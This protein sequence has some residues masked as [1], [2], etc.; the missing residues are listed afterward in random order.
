[1]L[2][3]SR[4]SL[5]ALFIFAYPAVALAYCDMPFLSRTVSE[6]ADCIEDQKHE[7]ANQALAI[8]SLEL[9]IDTLRLEIENLKSELNSRIFGVELQISTLRPYR[10]PLNKPVSPKKIQPEKN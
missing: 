4:L 3:L 5:L 1:M 6:L 2:N 10:P 7:L 9:A 8:S